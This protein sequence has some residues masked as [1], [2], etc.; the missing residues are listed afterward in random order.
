MGNWEDNTICVST[1]ITKDMHRHFATKAAEHGVTMSSLLSGWIEDYCRE[2]LLE[3][4]Q[5]IWRGVPDGT[6]VTGVHLHPDTVAEYIGEASQGRL[7]AGRIQIATVALGGSPASP[8]AMFNGVPVVADSTVEPG[9][10]V[11][12]SRQAFPSP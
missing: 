10:V 6:T 3:R 4:M 12:I 11:L 5:R 8:G 7:A 1:R 9:S 2:P